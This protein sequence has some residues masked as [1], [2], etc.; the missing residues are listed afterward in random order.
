MAIFFIHFFYKQLVKSNQCDIAWYRNIGAGKMP[1]FSPR[2]PHISP[3][4]LYHSA[5]PLTGQLAKP[6][7]DEL[8][9]T[10]R[11]H[12]GT[13]TEPCIWAETPKLTLL[14]KNANFS[15]M[16]L[17]CNQHVFCILGDNIYI[18]TIICLYINI[19]IIYIFYY[20]ISYYIISYHIRLY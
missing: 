16:I 5:A 10:P 17:G 3:W 14:G 15:N 13:H 19:Y 7:G 2:S 6:P 18:Y 12:T 11:D 9:G 20:I 8:S 4:A 1:T